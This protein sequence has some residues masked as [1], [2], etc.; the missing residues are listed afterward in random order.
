MANRMAY[1][2]YSGASSS[3]PT[4]VPMMWAQRNQMQKVEALVEDPGVV[5]NVDMSDGVPTALFPCVLC[6]RADIPRQALV[7]VRQI[8]EGIGFEAWKVPTG[9]NSGCRCGSKERCK[10]CFCNKKRWWRIL[11]RLCLVC[12]IY[13]F[14]RNDG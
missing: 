3:G 8:P 6:V 9:S 12:R 11:A 10:G 7:A 2:E 14:T 4:S 13:L 5:D 1:F